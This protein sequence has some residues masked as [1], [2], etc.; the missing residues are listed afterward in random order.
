MSVWSTSSTSSTASVTKIVFLMCIFSSSIDI[1]YIPKAESAKA[2]VHFNVLPSTSDTTL[3]AVFLVV[4]GLL[5][6]QEYLYSYCNVSSSLMMVSQ[7]IF[8]AKTTS[9]SVV[10]LGAHFHFIHKYIKYCKIKRETCC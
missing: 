10:E 1:S 8:I 5:Q 6:R 3:G 4:E 9:N 2:N 7:V